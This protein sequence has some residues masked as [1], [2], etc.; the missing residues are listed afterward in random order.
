MAQFD[1]L[2][3]KLSWPNLFLQELLCINEQDWLIRVE[4]ELMYV[5]GTNSGGPHAR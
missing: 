2:N 3:E 5:C 1:K 4:E